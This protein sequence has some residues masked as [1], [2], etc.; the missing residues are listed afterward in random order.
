MRLCVS[1]LAV[2]TAMGTLAPTPASPQ[3]VGLAFLPDGTLYFTDVDPFQ[4]FS[5]YMVLGSDT[6]LASVAARIET[7]PGIGIQGAESYECDGCNVVYD[8]SSQTVSIDFLP[9]HSAGEPLVVAKLNFLGLNDPGSQ[10]SICIAES[11]ADYVACDQQPGTLRFNSDHACGHEPA[12][13]CLFV[14][15]LEPC[16]LPISTES[17]GTV[18]ARHSQPAG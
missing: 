3:T 12:P 10:V 1:F 14:N 15:W 16:G 13:R 4:S 5:C 9:C 6:D 11:G 18:K 17:W 2:I 8:S 7:P